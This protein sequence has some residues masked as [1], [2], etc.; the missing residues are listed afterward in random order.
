MDGAEVRRRMYRAPTPRERERWHAVWLLA[1][2]LPRAAT[3]GGGRRRRWAESWSGMPIRLANGP[4]PAGRA[5]PKGWFLSRLVVPPRV[6]RGAKSR[7]EGGG[8]AIT[9]AVGYHAVQLELEGSAPICGRPL[10]VGAEPE[11]LSELSRVKHGTGSAP[12]GVC[13][14]A[15]QEAVAQ[16]RPSAGRGFRGRVCGADGGGSTDGDQAP[17]HRRDECGVVVKG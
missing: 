2:S 8:T 7:V 13:A 6:G 14:K 5:V 10:R 3:R 9:V 15:A 1:Q 12:V 16:S 17:I 4:K 11:Q